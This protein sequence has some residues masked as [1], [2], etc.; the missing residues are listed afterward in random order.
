M[1]QSTYKLDENY[2]MK[3][4]VTVTYLGK[5]DYD[6][7]AHLE[8]SYKEYKDRNYYM[9]AIDLE[10][11]NVKIHNIADLHWLIDPLESSKNVNKIVDTIL[12]DIYRFNEG[13]YKIRWVYDR[14]NVDKYSN[15]KPIY[16]NWETIVVTK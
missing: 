2:H 12:T 5:G 4:V 10:G 6:F 16:S 7:G 15:Q 14:A 9:E 13:K 1:L 11:N 8:Y 3:F